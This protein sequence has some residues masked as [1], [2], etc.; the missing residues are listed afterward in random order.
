[1]AITLIDSITTVLNIA[2][3]HQWVRETAGPNRGEIVDQIIKTTGLTPPIPWCAAFVAYIGRLALAKQWP[4]KPWAGCDPLAD[5]AKLK[6][7]F[8]V[9]PTK[10][11]I[12]LLWSE[13]AGFR[14]TGFV[15]DYDSTDNR[16]N[17]IEGNTSPDGS[18][19]GTGVFLRKRTFKDKDGFIRWWA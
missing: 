6:N 1:M 9:V 2:S 5:E 11:V 19:E 10:G 13:S 15:S 4:L 7:L 12:F 16:W 3:G 17:T 8:R 18:P 14:H